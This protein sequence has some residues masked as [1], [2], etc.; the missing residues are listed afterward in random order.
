MKRLRE[1]I[2]LYRIYR[3]AVRRAV[4]PVRT[5]AGLGA[6]GKTWIFTLS[7]NTLTTGWTK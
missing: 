3:I 1:A 2:A 6:G 5:S 4:R 7:G